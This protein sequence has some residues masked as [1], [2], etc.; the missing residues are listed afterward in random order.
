MRPQEELEELL[1]ELQGVLVRLSYEGYD[2]LGSC[3]G[4]GQNVDTHYH[5]PS[6]IISRALIAIEEWRE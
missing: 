6:C 4:C 1:D 5:L 3:C 2:P